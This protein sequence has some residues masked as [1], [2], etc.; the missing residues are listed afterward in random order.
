MTRGLLRAVPLPV[1]V[2]VLG[3]ATVA[4]MASGVVWGSVDVDPLR[5]WHIVSS[6]VVRQS[7]G[8]PTSTLA[9]E[10][11]VCEL[12]LPRVLL[13]AVAGASLSTVGIVVQAMVR[14]VLADPYVLGMS[15]GASVGASTVLLWG[16]LGGFGAFS[17]SA[18]AFVGALGALVVVF[19]LAAERG[20][21]SP[22]R[23]VLVGVA[24]S[25]V[26]SA[27]TSF[28][29]FKAD[30]RAARLV[31]FWLLGSFGRA[32]W[33]LIVLPALV[34]IGGVVYLLGRAR[35]LNA[36]AVGEETAV[37]LGV[38][39]AGLRRELFVVVSLMTGVVVAVSGAVGFV[40]LV[41]PHMARLLVGAD[42]RR[43][44]PVGLLLGA[45]FTVWGDL[46]ARMLVAPQ[47]MPIGVV[48]AFVGGPVFV[49]LVRRGQY[50]D[51]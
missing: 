11:I 19:A 13:A 25:F 45:T 7:P 44:L 26:L 40:G 2:V 6:K 20:R 23:L 8:L 30:P 15:S 1:V 27:L 12:R 22:L 51:A 33:A 29:V 38:D 42:H 48:T 24:L 14:N 50:S 37:A 36:L 46:L 10:R 4:A 17:L 21:L 5:V 39:P 41:L 28:L 43:V 18:A 49:A 47:E 34:L 9:E 35:P 3:V 32:S 16:A 31:L